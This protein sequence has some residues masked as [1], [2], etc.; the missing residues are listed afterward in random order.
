MST[1]HHSR[2]RTFPLRVENRLSEAGGSAYAWYYYLLEQHL[3]PD[4]T[5]RRRSNWVTGALIAVGYL[6]IAISHL[7]TGKA[8]AVCAGL[9]MLVLLASAPIRGWFR[10]RD[11]DTWF[12]EILPLSA[13]VSIWAAGILI[14][15]TH[16]FWAGLVTAVIGLALTMFT[17]T[18]A[19]QATMHLYLITA[20][21]LG[22]LIPGVPGALIALV[23][24]FF[25]GWVFAWWRHGK[26]TM[27][28]APAHM[29]P[30]QFDW[31]VPDPPTSMPYRLACEARAFE[32]EGRRQ[33]KNRT[34]GQAEADID[35]K[36]IGGA[37]ERKTALKL[38]GLEKGSARIIHDVLVPGSDRGANLDHL[39]FTRGGGWALDSKQFGS[40]A[41]PG[42][43]YRDET[44]D[45]V[46]ESAWG[47]RSMAGSLKTLAWA[48]SA[49]GQTLNVPMRGVL[50]V[51]TAAVEP[52]LSVRVD[53]PAP[54]VSAMVV[55]IVSSDYVV[56]YLGHAQPVMSSHHV[57]AFGWKAHNEL[58]SAG[59]FHRPR[60]VTPIGGGPGRATPSRPVP[61]EKPTETPAGFMGQAAR[62]VMGAV[63]PSGTQ[64]FPGENAM[65]F[66]ARKVRERWGF[67]SDSEPAAPDDVPVELRDVTAGTPLVNLGFTNDG[68]DIYSRNLVALSAP[69]QGTDGP[70]VWA[71]APEQWEVHQSTGRPVYAVTYKVD[72]VA[73]RHVSGEGTV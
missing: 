30:D 23:L 19:R 53:R 60:V 3:D 1:K 10:G 2:K 45:I 72:D 43:V 46:H 54:G 71:C 67:I 47:D 56:A 48:A 25:A 64:N 7:A 33:R 69:C 39:V 68:Q 14:C 66:S 36:K 55:D 6:I 44:G 8:L 62:S 16:G 61:Q 27:G 57:S 15:T 9:I 63:T 65:A 49:V 59:S 42:R 41:R 17:A 50:V 13:P 40:K 34:R 28:W 51:H 12:G 20:T 5:M 29:D 18:W 31:T 24:G 22:A 11:A 26:R 70:F 38:L 32:A 4:G 37:G 52:G 58:V 73:V 21:T 35:V